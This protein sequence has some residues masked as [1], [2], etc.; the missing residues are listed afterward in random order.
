MGC[1]RGISPHNK[2]TLMNKS[3]ALVQASLRSLRSQISSRT[4][5]LVQLSIDASGSMQGKK[6]TDVKSACI[7]CIEELADPCNRDAFDVE[8]NAFAG[9]AATILALTK[10]TEIGAE[11]LALEAQELGALT[12]IVAALELARAGVDAA[13]AREVRQ[14]RPAC[15]VLTDGLHNGGG[16]PVAAADALKRSADVITVAFGDD[17]ADGLLA[18]IASSAELAIRVKTGAELRSFFAAVGRSASLS[19]AQNRS[20][21]DIIIHDENEP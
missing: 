4:R 12:N 13:L 16:D 3:I 20:I 11:Q 5:Q 2:G 9:R 10:A 14:V 15:V 8:I 1:R 18:Q 7:A 21:A 19:L 6:L 17:A